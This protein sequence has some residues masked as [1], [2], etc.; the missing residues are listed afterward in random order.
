[1]KIIGKIILFLVALGLL[2]VAIYI[3]FIEVKTPQAQ[4]KTNSQVLSQVTS[5]Q[6]AVFKKASISGQVL[7]DGIVVAGS[8]QVGGIKYPLTNGKFTIN[9]LGSGVYPISYIDQ[10]GQEHK[11]DPASMQIFPGEI[12]D[13]SFSV[14]Y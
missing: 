4:E 3:Y 8:V 2:A 10:S 14:V 12:S 11:L 13:F 1:M 6:T 9:S 5:S 7:L